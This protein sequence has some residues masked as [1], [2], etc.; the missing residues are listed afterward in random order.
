MKEETTHYGEGRQ[1]VK[2]EVEKLIE[3]YLVEQPDDSSPA[4][5]EGFCKAFVK[6]GGVDY[7]M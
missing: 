6:I 1:S 5:I 4:D 3:K 2:R 7:E